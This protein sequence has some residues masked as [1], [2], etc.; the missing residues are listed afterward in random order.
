VGCVRGR[1]CWVIIGL[2]GEGVRVLLD[3]LGG[4]CR[5]WVWDRAGKLFDIFKFNIAFLLKLYHTRIVIS[6]I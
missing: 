5:I 3:G 6:K 2:G 1:G 4:G